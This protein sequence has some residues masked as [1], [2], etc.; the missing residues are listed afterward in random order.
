MVERGAERTLAAKAY[1][2]LREDIVRGALEPGSKLKLEEIGS[3]YGFGLAPLREAL[4]R[5]AGDSLVMTEG[6]RGYWVTPLSQQELEDVT[7][8]RALVEIEAVERAIRQGDAGWLAAVDEAAAALFAIEEDILRHGA[9]FTPESF[10]AWEGANERFHAVL[11]SACASPTFLGVRD[12]L[13]ARAERYRRV[14]RRFEP[15]VHEE[16]IALHHAVR[17]RNAVRACRLTEDHIVQ[18]G[19]GVSRFMLEAHRV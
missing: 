10:E 12:L 2:L 11:V 15:D 6:Q 9:V 17:E 14:A 16:H 5:L 3:R 13:Y 4:A 7:R 8:L 19:K 1:R 18:R